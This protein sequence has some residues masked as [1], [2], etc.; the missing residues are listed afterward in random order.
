MT[1]LYF[2]LIVAL[3]FVIS[4]VAVVVCARITGPGS[5]HVEAT[6]D[7][8]GL[9]EVL[10]V[11]FNSL[12]LRG[13]HVRSMSRNCSLPSWPIWASS[14]ARSPTGSSTRAPNC[15][16]KFRATCVFFRCYEGRLTTERDLASRIGESPI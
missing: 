16:M 8:V 3:C 4:F 11:A 10:P 14:N 2:V 9:D 12:G 15:D 5:K 1:D 6:N 7:L 13:P